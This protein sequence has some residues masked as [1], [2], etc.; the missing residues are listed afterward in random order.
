MLKDGVVLVPA[1]KLYASI[2][3][4]RSLFGR[5]VAINSRTSC[6]VQF[7]TVGQSVR[8]DRTARTSG[9]CSSRLP[10]GQREGSSKEFS[11]CGESRN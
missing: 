7:S 1:W 3:K 8:T 2:H 4:L 11:I 6:S 10:L 9:V 5:S